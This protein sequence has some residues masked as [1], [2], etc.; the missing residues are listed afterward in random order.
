MKK[1]LIIA[2][3]TTLMVSCSKVYEGQNIDPNNP[4]AVNAET[5]LKGIQLANI[6]VQ[7]SHIQRITAMW[8]GQ[9]KGATLLYKSLG[10]YSISKTSRQQVLLRYYQDN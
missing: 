7:V 1:I 2:V 3:L 4:T 10:E 9:Y 6:T 5:L 8:M